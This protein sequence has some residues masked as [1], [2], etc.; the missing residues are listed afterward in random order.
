MHRPGRNESNLLH[1]GPLPEDLKDVQELNLLFLFLLQNRARQGAEC[2][3]LAAPV[4]RRIR[5]ASD[6]VLRGMSAFPRTVFVL[7]LDCLK[8]KARVREERDIQSRRARHAFALTA[9]LTA[10]NMARQRSFHGRVFLGLSI[11]EC[12]YLA[13][14]PM[15]KLHKLAENPSMVRCAFPEAVGL[16]TRLLQHSTRGLPATLQMLGLQPLLTPSA[17]EPRKSYSPEIA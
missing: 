5:T 4:T 15:M 2:F 1:P 8:S 3:G 10:W 12:H 6:A 7:D 16:W 9:V 17:A 14:L 11:P 13:T